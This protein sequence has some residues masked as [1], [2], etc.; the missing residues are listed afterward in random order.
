MRCTFSAMFTI[1]NQVEKARTRSRAAAGGT[2]HVR[3]ASSCS[4]S[5]IAFAARDRGLSIAFDGLEQ[6]VAA[7]LANHLADQR[8]E[9]VHVFAQLGVFERE[10]KC[11]SAA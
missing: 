7:L 1:S 10:R 9:H 6:V 11:R 8:T 5:R 4:P 2:L 3:V